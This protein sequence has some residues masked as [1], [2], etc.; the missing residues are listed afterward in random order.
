[1]LTTA[2]AMGVLAFQLTGKLS[3]SGA[4]VL[5]LQPLPPLPST[6]GLEISI[7]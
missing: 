6:N 1:M 5:Y 4:W 2:P 3:T 7:T